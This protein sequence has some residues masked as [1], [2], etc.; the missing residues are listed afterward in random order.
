MGLPGMG[1][2][3]KMRLVGGGQEMQSH[4]VSSAFSTTP[5]AGALPRG[6]PPSP[7][8]GRTAHCSFSQ[9]R[10]GPKPLSVFISMITRSLGWV[11]DEQF[12]LLIRCLG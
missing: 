12:V 7:R 10:S 11:Q 3:T 8:L 9:H 1:D 4:R 6:S 2:A 5:A